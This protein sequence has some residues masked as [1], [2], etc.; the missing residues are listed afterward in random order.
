M[1]LMHRACLVPRPL[2][3][4]A[5]CENLG[6]FDHAPWQR[7]LQEA[8]VKL[9]NAAGVVTPP[10]PHKLELTPGLPQGE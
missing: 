4:E 2:P 7:C 1:Q 5:L 9:S 10:G 8:E 6:G 3:I